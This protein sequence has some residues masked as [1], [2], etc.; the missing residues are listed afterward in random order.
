[1]AF[2]K[3]TA[4]DQLK[5]HVECGLDAPCLTALH[6]EVADVMACN[7]MLQAA[8]ERLTTAYMASTQREADI[9]RHQN[10]LLIAQ[11]GK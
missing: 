11:G 7:A 3:P 5:L 9:R 10:D 1:M 2:R 6:E 8:N 4:I